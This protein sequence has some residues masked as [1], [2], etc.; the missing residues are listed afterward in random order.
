MAKK[1]KAKPPINDEPPPPTEEQL[2]QGGWNTTNGFVQQQSSTRKKLLMYC[3]CCRVVWEHVTLECNRVAIETSERF[4]DGLATLEELK[5]RWDATRF[6]PVVYHSWLLDAL[7]PAKRDDSYR[8]LCPSSH[9]DN[10]KLNAFQPKR[11]NEFHRW[12][13]SGWAESGIDVFGHVLH[14]SA[15]LLPAWRT[16]DVLLL[17]QGIY[18]D[19]AFDRMPILADALQ[20]AGCADEEILSHCRDSNRRHVRGCWVVDLVLG[21][22]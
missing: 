3:G 16:S 14:P 21:K 4:A 15:A 9:E 10:E 12:V 2:R 13:H 22:E 11:T 5:A 7:G 18:D 17:A 6:E 19:Y 8:Q 1:R 20:D